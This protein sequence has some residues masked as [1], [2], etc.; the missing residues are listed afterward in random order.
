MEHSPPDPAFRPAPARSF[1]GGQVR[2]PKLGSNEGAAPPRIDFVGTAFLGGGTTTVIE[3]PGPAGGFNSYFT[4]ESLFDEPE[5]DDEL[6]AED[7]YVVLKVTRDMPW[8][9][10]VSAHRSLVKE[11]HPDRF[12]DHPAEVVAEAEHEIKRINRAYSEL[13]KLRADEG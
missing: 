8:N 4:T 6:D 10:I 5:P 3:D 7:P 9:E 13:R 12:V 2:L 11:F 1:P